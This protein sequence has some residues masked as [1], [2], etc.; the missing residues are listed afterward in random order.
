MKENEVPQQEGA[1]GD[2]KE[3]CYATD[4]NGNYTT[5]LSAGWEVKKIALE[6]SLALLNEQIAQAKAAMALAALS[7]II[8]CSIVWTG[9]YSLVLCIA[10][11]GL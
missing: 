2:I 10:G 3:L 1:L 7:P 8:C 9:R 11:S 4:T 5:C 6:A